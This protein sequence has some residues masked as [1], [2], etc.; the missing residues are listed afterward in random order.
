MP[1]GPDAV[2]GRP[3]VRHHRI[4]AL[5]GS[6][7]PPKPTLGACPLSAVSPVQNGPCKKT[8]CLL[9]TK[10]ATA[11]PVFAGCVQALLPQLS[12]LGKTPTAP[13]RDIPR[14]CSCRHSPTAMVRCALLCAVALAAAACV[15]GV[16]D[17]GGAPT[18]APNVHLSKATRGMPQPWMAP[19]HLRRR[20]QVSPTG[21]VTFNGGRVMTEAVNV[22]YIWYG[23]WTGDTTTTI[24]PELTASLGTCGR[25][26]GTTWNVS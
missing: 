23:N 13:A 11:A 9:P 25:R 1:Y 18:K 22:Y 21:A 2:E 10:R 24:L 4:T 3:Q 17:D 8:H 19:P 14:R 15:A 5:P 16:S 6:V 12:A 26:R 20:A 7:W